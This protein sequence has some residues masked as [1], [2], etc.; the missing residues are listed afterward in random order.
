MSMRKRIQLWLVVALLVTVSLL[1]P[2]LADDL[3]ATKSIPLEVQI[4][5]AAEVKNWS[6]LAELIKQGCDVNAAQV[7]G[8]T[9]VH[10]AVYHGHEATVRRLIRSQCD[11]NVTTRYHMTPL[12][13]ACILGDAEIVKLLLSA[14]ADAN[15]QQPGG[16]TPLMI[17]S[18]TGNA[19][20]VRWLI[21]HSA[22]VN[23]RE[24][25]GQTAL[26]WAAA[27]GNVDAVD[28]LINASA[29]VNASLDSGFTAMMFAAREGRMEITKR[30]VR[31]GVDVNLVM[32]P[33]RTSGRAPRQGTSA[34]ILAV[35]SGHFELA[36]FLVH[37]GADPNDQRSGFTPLHA[38]SRVRKTNIREDVSGDPPPRGSGN[39][40]SLQFVRAIVQTGADVNARLQTG[41]GGPAVMNLKGATPLLMAGKTADVALISTLLEIGADPHLTNVDGCTLLMAAAGVGVY[42]VGAEAG[43]E[44]E[45]L[46][47]L[48]FL[49]ARGL[50]VNAVDEN[51]ETVMHG[52]AYRNFPLAVDYLAK[53]GA[54]PDVWNHKNKY[55]WTPVMIAQGNRPGSFKPSPE[56]VRALRAVM[57]ASH[58]KQ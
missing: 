7:D 5:D 26:M 27:E 38:I 10:W 2:S 29:D 46:E 42:M 8:M 47:A 58:N 20:A 55:G 25:N 30:L 39:L 37:C 35:E 53:Q 18:R 16:E 24:R 52:A 50:D 9:A 57:S 17:A 49:V 36:M 23:S 28:I 45:V 12:S 15:T 1:V 3:N 6:E 21:E 22:K 40:T 44:P 19:K 48:G 54:D 56:T 41:K 14:G 33:K 4:A 31:A 32:H 51:K 13:I 43:T 34:L 11:V